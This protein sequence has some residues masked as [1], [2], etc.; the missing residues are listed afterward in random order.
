MI[1]TILILIVGLYT[2][3]AIQQEIISLKCYNCTGC[4]NVNENTSIAVG[5]GGCT[6]KFDDS[7]VVR[8]CVPSCASEYFHGQVCCAKNLCNDKVFTSTINEP[9]KVVSDN[10]PIIVP[11][12]ETPETNL[13]IKTTPTIGNFELMLTKSS[14]LIFYCLLWIFTFL[15]I[16]I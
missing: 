2:V 7:E 1:N 11:T 5:C 9:G 12:E 13:E 6:M 10:N 15:H 4:F 14:F 8:G 16:V 3:P